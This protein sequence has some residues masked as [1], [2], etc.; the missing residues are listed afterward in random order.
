MSAT[1]PILPEFYLDENV[2]APE[3]VEALEAVGAT[4]HRHRDHFP[5]GVPD[6]DWLPF[7]G[8]QGWVIL[9]RD[10]RIRYRTVERLALL[11]AGARAFVLASKA[12]TALQMA[13]AVT[14]GF[15][16]M[17]RFL[18]QHQGPFIAKLYR[19]G[20]VELWTQQ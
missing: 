2:S 11:N 14:L 16:A 5:A 8:G 17:C 6:A 10:A 3:I 9:T 18:E 4:V 1:P 20:R 15:S 13:Y 12:M 19:D 7:V